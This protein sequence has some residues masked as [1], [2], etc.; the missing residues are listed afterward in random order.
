MYLIHRFMF[1]EQETV[2]CSTW[3]KLWIE[4]AGSY[5]HSL[6]LCLFC[7]SSQ[8]TRFEIKP[9]KRNCIDIYAFVCF[10]SKKNLFGRK[11]DSVLYYTQMQY[12]FCNHICFS[13]L[14]SSK[15]YCRQRFQ[16]WIVN[17]LRVLNFLKSFLNMDYIVKNNHF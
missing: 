7:A 9:S 12:E 11:Y 8:N 13:A 16:S 15:I 3:P 17:K 10:S 14:V 4:F 2:V 5:F 1:V 6:I